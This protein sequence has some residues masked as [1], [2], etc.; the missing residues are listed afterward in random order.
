MIK[1]I[2]MLS[3]RKALAAQAWCLPHGYPPQSPEGEAK[4]SGDAFDYYLR[5][6]E[7]NFSLEDV[8]IWSDF[9]NKFIKHRYNRFDCPNKSES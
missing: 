9:V 6:H 8:L 3:Y 2:P 5:N 1:N 7:V 4:N